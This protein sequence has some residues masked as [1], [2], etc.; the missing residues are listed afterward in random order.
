MEAHA[1]HIVVWDAPAAVERAAPLRFKVGVKCAAECSS[2]GR[3]VAIRDAQGRELASAV[4]GDVAWP[5]TAAL[6]YAEFELPAPDA[7]GLHAW[8]AAL[9]ADAA[10]AP[11]HAPHAAAT[12]QF[13]VRVVPAPECTV[14]VVAVDAASRT[15][16]GGARVVVHPYR[17]VTDSQGIAELRVPKGAYR[18]FVSGRDYFPFRSDG[19][20][21]AD[22]TIEAELYADRGPSDAELWS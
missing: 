21:R 18:L 6:N 20:V 9:E 7:D 4:V 10:A 1:T 19:D 16:V 17:A 5:G 15:P 2:A 14:K 12:S 8:V 22:V 3:R 13:Q 11:D